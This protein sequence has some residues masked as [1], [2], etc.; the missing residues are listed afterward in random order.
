MDSSPR[1]SSPHFTA[2]RVRRTR[3]SARVEVS[4]HRTRQQE[5]QAKRRRRTTSPVGRQATSTCARRRTT[6][7]RDSPRAPQDRQKGSS[8]PMGMRHSITALCDVRSRPTAVSPR[9]S[10]PGKVVKS[11]REKVV[12]ASVF[13]RGVVGCGGEGAPRPGIM[14]IADVRARPGEGRPRGE[15][16]RVV[17]GCGRGVGGGA[18][19]GS[20]GGEAADRDGAGRGPGRRAVGGPGVLAQATGGARPGQDHRGPGP[21]RGPG[22][23]SPV[24]PGP[25][26]QPGGALR[27]GRLRPHGLPPGQDPGR[28]RGGRRGG[29][30]GGPGGGEAQGVVPGRRALAGGRYQRGESA[31]DRRGRHPGGG[32]L[33]QG[34]RCPHLQGRV[35]LPPPDRLVR[36]RPRRGRAV[37][38]DHAAAGQRGGEHRRRPHRGDLAGPGPGGPGIQTGQESAGAHRRGRGHEGDRGVPRPPQG[39][40]LGGVQAPRLSR[41]RSTRR[42]PRAP[43]PRPTTPTAT[44]GRGRTWRRS[45]AC[46]T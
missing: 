25:A 33:R 44:P 46:W 40:L 16:Y 14:R 37:R 17:P 28:G 18:G 5:V 19:G 11:G 36:P 34:G 9:A 43:G 41:R 24:G 4:H 3:G 1:A 26:A 2:E 7:P 21:V 12:L 38:G 23:R 29:R 35:R 22:R 42:S 30:G 32:P 31:G 8:K 10:S 6:V 39:V 45:P 20:G 15:W 27:P 13:R